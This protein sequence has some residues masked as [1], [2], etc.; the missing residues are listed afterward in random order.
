MQA[1]PLEI[2]A[3]INIS[4]AVRRYISSADC[5]NQATGDFAKACELLRTLLR[6]PS[7]FVVEDRG[8]HYLVTS[9]AQGNFEIER[10]AVL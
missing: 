6:R 9:D 5:M 8:R 2:E 3:R 4:L 10:V 7:R 1:P